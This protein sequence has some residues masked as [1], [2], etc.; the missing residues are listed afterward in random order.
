MY[1]STRHLSRGIEGSQTDV[2]PGLISVHFGDSGWMDTKKKPKASSRQSE[3]SRQTQN[4]TCVDAQIPTCPSFYADNEAG[5]CCNTCRAQKRV[6]E[7]GLAHRF[8]LW[9]W[10]INSGQSPTARP[11]QPGLACSGALNSERDL[12]A[13][14]FRDLYNPKR[15]LLGGPLLISS[16]ALHG[17]AL[18][19]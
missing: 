12:E 5:L 6:S 2:E 1:S 16:A 18:L 15:Q 11:G 13:S 19:I 4:P 17:N 7:S 3:Q 10:I 8:S 9:T 14:R